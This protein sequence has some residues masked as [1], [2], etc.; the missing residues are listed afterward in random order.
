MQFH[1]LAEPIFLQRKYKGR[2]SFSSVLENVAKVYSENREKII[3]QKEQM[4]IVFN[5]LNKKNAVLKQNLE[6]FVERM[7][8][9]LDE[10]NGGFKGAPKFPQFYMFEAIFYF[11]KKITKIVLFCQLKNF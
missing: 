9:Y 11:L 3:L 6:P 10:K 2:P 7:L 1:L 4:E 8:Q 5:E